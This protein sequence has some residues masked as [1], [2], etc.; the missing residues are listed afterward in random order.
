MLPDTAGRVS[1]N[2]EYG[3]TWMSDKTRSRVAV[4]INLQYRSPYL[5]SPA[6]P[7]ILDPVILKPL[8]LCEWDIYRIER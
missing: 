4:R 7:A 5:A 2:R 1:F 8:W 6:S 3:C